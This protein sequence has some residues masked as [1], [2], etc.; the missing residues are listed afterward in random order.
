MREAAFCFWHNPAT[1]E[2]VADA[3]RL[4]GVR[5]RRERAVAGAYDFTG[6]STVESITRLLEIAVFD[7][8]ALDNSLAR[9]RTLISAGLAGAKLLE[10]GDLQ[11]RIELLESIARSRP[12]DPT[13]SLGPALLDTA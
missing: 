12:P 4:G 10:T 11:T 1:T 9:C 8:L 6:L 2:E 13:D 3:Q 7:A 5:R